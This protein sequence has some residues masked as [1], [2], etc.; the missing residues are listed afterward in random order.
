[1]TES[2]IDVKQ[3]KYFD[4]KDTPLLRRFLNPHGRI[5]SR[6]RTNLTEKQQHALAKAVKYSRFMA[7]IPFVEQ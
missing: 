1:M 5:M 4:Y 7:L 2:S 6:R 3:I